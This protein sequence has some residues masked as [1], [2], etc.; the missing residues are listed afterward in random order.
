MEQEEDRRVEDFAKELG[1]ED[2]SPTSIKTYSAILSKFYRKYDTISVPN[3]KKFIADGISEK[4]SYSNSY[5][6]LILSFFP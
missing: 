5:K 6:F 2:Y 4:K 1:K 3:I